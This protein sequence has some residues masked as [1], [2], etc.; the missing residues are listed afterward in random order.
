MVKC[1]YVP[2][3]LTESRTACLAMNLEV[4]DPLT[5]TT[6]YDKG[7]SIRGASGMSPGRCNTCG[8]IRPMKK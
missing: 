1:A 6:P 7:N 8:R 2:Q 4:I 3:C 5:G